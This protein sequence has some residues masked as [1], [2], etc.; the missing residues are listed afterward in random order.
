MGFR[1]DEWGV[2]H[3]EYLPGVTL[4]RK[5]DGSV[6]VIGGDELEAV[7]LDRRILPFVVK[8]LQGLIDDRP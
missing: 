6:L 8:Y 5:P 3:V 4:G 2:D 7:Q 1:P